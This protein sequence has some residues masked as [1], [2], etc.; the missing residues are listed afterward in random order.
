MTDTARAFLPDWPRLAGRLTRQAEL[1]RLCWFRA[2]GA[3]EFLYEPLDVDE[4]Q[5]FL[6]HATPELPRFVL[7]AGSNVLIRDGGIAGVV[8][9][10]RRH[11]SD[12]RLAAPCLI[13]AQSGT[14][15]RNIA[16][17]AARNDIGEFAFLDGIPGTLGGALRMNAG[18]HG[19]EIADLIVDADWLD[20]SGQRHRLQVGEM[21]FSYRHCAVPSDWIAIGARL[22]GASQDHATIRATMAELRAVRAD[23]QPRTGRTGGSTFRNPDDA[24]QAGQLGRA[25]QWIDRAHCRGLRM[26]RVRVSEK[27]CNFLIADD[28]AEA[29]EIERLGEELRR[30]VLADS[31][32]V[33]EWE[34]QRVG[35][36]ERL[37]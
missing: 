31:G 4:L 22:R 28:G 36:A 12:M 1:R 27:H 15:V 14:M 13:E 19:A 34:I 32:I 8:I 18:A 30:R 21:G 26:G 5:N 29:W 33:L 20:G 2:G 17:F 7:G 25:W 16:D 3:A 10:M 9:R 6:C 24:D 37:I 35:L 23:T 11:F